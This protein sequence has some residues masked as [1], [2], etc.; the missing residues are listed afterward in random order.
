MQKMFPSAL[1]L[2]SLLSVDDGMCWRLK[3]KSF[4][5]PL[6]EVD[7]HAG[8]NDLS[9]IRDDFP[10]WRLQGNDKKTCVQYGATWDHNSKKAPPLLG[11]WMNRNF[12]HPDITKAWVQLLRAVNRRSNGFARFA[13]L[14]MSN[15]EYNK[16]NSSDIPTIGRIFM[17]FDDQMDP[18]DIFNEN[19]IPV[20][21]VTCFKNLFFIYV[22][23]AQEKFPIGNCGSEFDILIHKELP[24]MGTQVHY[25]YDANMVHTFKGPS[26]QLGDGLN[27]SMDSESIIKKFH[28]MGNTFITAIPPVNP[29][30]GGSVNNDE[31]GESKFLISDNELSELLSQQDTQRFE[32][33]EKDYL[34]PVPHRVPTQSS[35]IP[36]DEWHEP[37]HV[38]EKEEDKIIL[39][40][41]KR[42][43]G[44]FSSLQWDYA[45]LDKNPGQWSTLKGMGGNR[46]QREKMSHFRG[47]EEQKPENYDEEEKVILRYDW[48]PDI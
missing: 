41:Y 1:F 4:L 35:N 5:P 32:K 34:I 36:G 43:L 9:V 24:T 31:K 15:I 30:F 10:Q 17:F 48:S 45:K 40:Q 2:M 26:T 37:P 7:S 42:L 14:G 33:M 25:D 13:Q 3:T 20:E 12:D 11:M 46:L 19:D 27:D 47:T 23:I 6:P 29:R 21:M 16:D 28:G 8:Q 39:S 38:A 22:K 18:E 44:I